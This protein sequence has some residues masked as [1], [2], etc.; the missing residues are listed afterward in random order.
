MARVILCIVEGPDDT[1]KLPGNVDRHFRHLADLASVDPKLGGACPDLYGEL[2]EVLDRFDRKPAQLWLGGL[3]RPVPV[4][5]FGLQCVLDSALGSVHAMRDL[6]NFARQLASGDLRSVTRRLHRWLSRSAQHTMTLAMDHASGATPARLRRIEGERR[7]ALLDDSFNLPFPFIGEELGVDDLGDAF[8]APVR[9][10]APT[11][12]CAGTLDGRTPVSNAE[13]VMCGFPNGHLI[14][15]DGAAHEVPDLLL[16]AHMR[17]LE[18]REVDVDRLQRPFS[19]AAIE[20]G[21]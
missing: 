10:D 20:H 2:A 13:A 16:D 14:V 17:F 18:G 6:P 7:R 5:R 15:V 1:H 19:F 12:F 9:T 3:E 4:G 11:L 8:R 21:S